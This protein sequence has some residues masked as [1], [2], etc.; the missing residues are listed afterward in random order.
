MGVFIQFKRFAGILRDKTMDYK[1]KY[2]PEEW[3]LV[4]PEIRDRKPGH[5][6]SLSKPFGK[7]KL[8]VLLD[9]NQPSKIRM[10]NITRSYKTLVTSVFYKPMSPP[11]L[12]ICL[13]IKFDSVWT[14]YAKYYFKM[15]HTNKQN[16]SSNYFRVVY[17]FK[18]PI[19]FLFSK[20]SFKNIM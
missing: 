7:I 14:T 6:L 5:K 1:L 13:Y 9:W 10:N 16:L 15:F 17:Y 8:L 19:L 20:Y 4:N 18:G 2:I 11:S 3:W 12:G